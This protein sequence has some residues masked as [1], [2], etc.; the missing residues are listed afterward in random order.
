[1]NL[2]GGTVSVHVTIYYFHCFSEVDIKCIA[3]ELAAIG[4]TVDILDYQLHAITL[5]TIILQQVLPR[6]VSLDRVQA[7]CFL[8]VYC[9]NKD[10]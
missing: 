9:G 2:I 7:K 6:V 8:P 10:R 4:L 5:K 3:L 1:M